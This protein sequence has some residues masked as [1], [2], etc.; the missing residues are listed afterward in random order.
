MYEEV[1]FTKFGRTKMVPPKIYYNEKRVE[2][3]SLRY[4]NVLWIERPEDW[5]GLMGYYNERV[6]VVTREDFLKAKD[7][8]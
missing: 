7:A 5:Y 3:D 2:D 6:L 1:R 8:E 4:N